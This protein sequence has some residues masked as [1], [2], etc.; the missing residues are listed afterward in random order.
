MMLMT[1]A[2]LMAKLAALW[3]ERGDIEQAKSCLTE[4]A[5]L[6]QLCEAPF[7]DDAEEPGIRLV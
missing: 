4:A 2:M 5:R 6:T 3:L 1:Q 7:G